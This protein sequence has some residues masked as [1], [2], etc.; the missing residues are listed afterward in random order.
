MEQEP[1]EQQQPDAQPESREPD[2]QVFELKSKDLS[3]VR[4]F[5]A[6]LSKG[7]AAQMAAE[8]CFCDRPDCAAKAFH[9]LET[10]PEMKEAWAIVKASVEKQVDSLRKEHAELGKAYCDL[11]EK[12][13]QEHERN[14]VLQAALDEANK[15]NLNLIKILRRVSKK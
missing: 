15:A 10:H 6:A 4:A 12:W 13:Q 14:D 7:A 2:S 11:K 8:G 9:K 5:M 1:Q 3:D